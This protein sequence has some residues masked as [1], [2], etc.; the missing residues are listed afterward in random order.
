MDDI[1][2][3][4]LFR[5]KIT[6][7]YT[8]DAKEF[9]ENSK[10]YNFKKIIHQNIELANTLNADGVHLTSNQFLDIPKAKEL[11]LLTIISTHSIEE[12]KKAQ[13]LGADIVTFSPIFATPNK[14]KPKGIAKLKEAIDCCDI[15][16]I[17]LG[18]IVTK[19][20]IEQ[21]TKTNAYGFASIRYFTTF[22]V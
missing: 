13:Q 20:Q 3:F 10:D 17:A 14:G 18:G 19:E 5:D 6:S 9:I 2:D 11:S 7:T 15:K 12:I 8:K 1:A 4:V 21:I 22:R 16:V